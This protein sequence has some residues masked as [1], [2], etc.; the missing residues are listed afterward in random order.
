MMLSSRQH[1]SHILLLSSNWKMDSSED[2]YGHECH[3]CQSNCHWFLRGRNLD[4]KIPYLNSVRSLMYVS[5]ACPEITNAVSH[6]EK[7][8]VN[9]G[10]A[11]WM[12]AQCVICYL[13]GTHDQQLVLGGRQ[14]I[15]LHGYVDSDFGQ[16][17]DNRK[18][19]SRYSFS[20]G[21]RAI[22]GPH[23]KQATVA[24]SSTEAEY[25]AADH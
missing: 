18:S 13:N 1:A 17:L 8:S 7:Y 5:M 6:L 21:S 3:Y 4:G 24:G 23:Q 16:D 19:V 9:P 15:A 14:P 2:T 12:A 25:I 11:H 10:Q 22:C 20:L